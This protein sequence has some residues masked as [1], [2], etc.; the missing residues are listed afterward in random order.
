MLRSTILGAVAIASLFLT[1][2]E[3]ATPGRSLGA[4]EVK[5]GEQPQQRTL[6]YRPDAETLVLRYTHSHPMLA[7]LGA[8]TLEVWGDGRVVATVPEG[9]RGAGRREWRLSVD[10]L[11]AMIA[12]LVADGLPSYDPAAVSRHKAAVPE[13]HFHVSDADRVEIRLFLELADGAAKTLTPHTVAVSAEAPALHAQ[14]Y[15]GIASLQGL[16]ASD[17]RLRGLLNGEA[18]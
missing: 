14:R 2:C 9:L 18:R 8:S 1:G 13:R 12:A 16:A 17:A 3:P 6:Y 15:P 7:H 11:D 4:A 10:E 5:L